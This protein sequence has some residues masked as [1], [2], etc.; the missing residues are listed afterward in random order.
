MGPHGTATCSPVGTAVTCSLHAAPAAAGLIQE[1][2]E[3]EALHG[4]LL[5][6]SAVQQERRPGDAAV[7]FA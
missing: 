5:A 7:P 1:E 2:E 4:V 3:E 6:S